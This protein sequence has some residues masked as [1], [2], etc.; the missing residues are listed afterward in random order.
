VPCSISCSGTG[1]AEVAIERSD[2][3]VVDALLGA[4]LTVVVISPHQVK[5]PGG[6][7]GSAG[8]NDD[9]FDA[10][11]LAFLARFDCKRPRRL[12]LRETPRG[13]TGQP[14]YSGRVDAVVLHAR[15]AG[16]PRGATGEHGAPEAHVTRALLAVLISD[17]AGW[18]CWQ[19]KHRLRPALPRLT[20]HQQQAA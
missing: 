15:L 11:V 12:A 7:C 6:R 16:A 14:R 1:V 2:G 9:R 10:F 19:N 3:P 13:M 18:H 20:Q 4:G 8:N 17:F 5:N